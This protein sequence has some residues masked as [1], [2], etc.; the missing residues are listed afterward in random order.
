[1]SATQQMGVFKQPVRA[2]F[3]IAWPYEHRWAFGEGSPCGSSDL[4]RIEH[5]Q[6]KQGLTCADGYENALAIQQ[7][8]IAA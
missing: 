3:K 1:M 2:F 8:G 4:A 7:L 6:T 5:G